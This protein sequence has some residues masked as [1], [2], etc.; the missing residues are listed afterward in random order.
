[1]SDFAVEAVFTS[2]VLSWSPPQEPNGGIIAYEVSYRSNNQDPITRNTTNVNIT[3]F[4]TPEFLPDTNVSTI[5]VRAYTT[6]GPGDA[7][8][9][10]YVIIPM[11]PVPRE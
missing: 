2:I 11:E 6:V 7:A 5:S 9:Q 3:T 10:P 8:V 4:T 1:M